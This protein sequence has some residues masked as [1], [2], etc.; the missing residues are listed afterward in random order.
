MST[1]VFG[2]GH[3]VAGRYR[4]ERL[5]GQGGM[6]SVYRAVQLSVGR[7]VALKLLVDEH[8]GSAALLER[9]QREAVALS[10]LT[11]ENTVRLF[12]FGTSERGSPFLV[13]E[14]LRG[15]DLARDLELQGALRHD[16]ALQVTR[17]ILC[18]LSEAH[19]AGIVHRDIKPGNV[20]LCAASA[21]PRVKVLDFGI[22]GGVTA[23]VA[24][25]RLTRTGTVLGSAAYMSPEQAQGLAV[26]AASDLYAVGVVLF[27]MLTQRTLFDARPLTAQLLA[28][29]MERAPRL[30]DVCPNLAVPREL[31][32]LVAELLERDPSRRPASAR[33]LLA[34]VDTLLDHA[35]LPP[36]VRSVADATPSAPP[37]PIQTLLGMPK[38]PTALSPPASG[39]RG[40][41]ETEPMLVLPSDSDGWAPRQS[42]GSGAAPAAPR[43]RRRAGRGGACGRRS[44]S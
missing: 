30:R 35:A 16:H 33:A 39:A 15:V 12:D 1:A 20:F 41:P 44:G 38:P 22:V 40:I 11:H 13:M 42:E 17:Q 34:R 28:K 3:V 18:S 43:R 37:A 2:P 26:G 4:I 14:F 8:D 36:L 21:W 23:D 19:D 31:E 27:E 7:T 6:G 5:L 29:V 25:P 32:A 9:F 10:R 24:A